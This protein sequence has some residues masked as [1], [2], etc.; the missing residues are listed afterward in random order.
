MSFNDV[1]YFWSFLTYPPTLSYFI[2]SSFLGYVRPPLPT[3]ILDVINGRSLLLFPLTQFFISNLVESPRYSHLYEFGL[4]G[5]FQVT[6]ILWCILRLIQYSSAVYGKGL[7][8]YDI[9]CFGIIRCILYN[10]SL[11]CKIRF[12]LTA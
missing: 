10:I 3:L 4:S 6:R 12:S 9:R 8:I 1:P 5:F 11:F 7:F 2:T